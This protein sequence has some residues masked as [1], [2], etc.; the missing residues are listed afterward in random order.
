MKMNNKTSIHFL[1][2]ICIMFLC[3][4]VACKNKHWFLFK[5]II[6]KI[7][8]VD[9]CWHWDYSFIKP[10]W[11]LIA[12]TFLRLFWFRLRAKLRIF[13]GW[14]VIPSFFLPKINFWRFTFLFGLDNLLIYFSRTYQR[15]IYIKFQSFWLYFF[16]S[17]WLLVIFSFLIWSSFSF[18][19]FVF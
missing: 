5:N 7:M 9:R 19:L 2:T 4:I 15:F 8:L 6:N 17:F 12:L 11:N 1:F 13:L 16:Y 14:A 18:L 3:L 10:S